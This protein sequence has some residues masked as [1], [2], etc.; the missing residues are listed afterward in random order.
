MAAEIPARK[1]Q[2]IT[3]SSLLIALQR[4]FNET[5]TNVSYS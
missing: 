1:S 3:L 4:T 5:R 2:F